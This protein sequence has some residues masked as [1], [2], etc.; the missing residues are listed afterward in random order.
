MENLSLLMWNVGARTILY[1]PNDQYWSALSVQ[2]ACHSA[3]NQSNVHLIGTSRQ[4]LDSVC[5]LHLFSLKGRVLSSSKYVHFPFIF[6][7]FFLHARM[8]HDP[9]ADRSSPLILL[10]Q[11]YT[12][13][14]HST[15]LVV[16]ETH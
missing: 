15:E 8:R 2:N 10:V 12:P 4:I 3:G 14:F 13:N 11:M 1:S 5:K 16:S 7:I 6:E 9:S